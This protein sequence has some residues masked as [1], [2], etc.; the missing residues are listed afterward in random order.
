VLELE[1]DLEHAAGEL[2]VQVAL[3]VGG[4]ETLALAGPSGAGKTTILRLIAGLARPDR[5]RIVCDG[6]VWLDTAHGLSL[7]PERRSCGYVFQEYALF[8]H[9]R[10]WENVGYGMGAVPR[11]LR[12]ERARGLLARFG[13]EALADA[14]PATLSG[15]ERQRVALARALAREPKVLLLDEPLSALDART[16]ASAGRA[17]AALLAEADV[18]A[19]LVTHDF[20][21]ASLLADRVAVID[22]GSIVQEGPAAELAAA[23]ASAFVADFT[24]ASV[25]YGEATAGADGLTTVALDGGGTVV[26]TDAAA[27]RV[28][29]SVFPWDVALEPER[30]DRQGSAQN[31]VEASVTSVTRIGNR[32]RVGL[33]TPQPLVCE[34]TEPAVRELALESG[35]R[36]AATWKATATRLTPVN[37]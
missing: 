31:R 25:L 37:G 23:P 3:G 2:A 6:E 35:A 17:L 26:S 34:V 11:R 5:G 19:L 33:E 28:A 1:F 32:V 24:G 16:R 8:P 10:A 27:G 21:E 4:G 14:R 29:A 9:L 7:A 36:V 13:I 30:S 20:E 18:P 15:G 12:P 22:R